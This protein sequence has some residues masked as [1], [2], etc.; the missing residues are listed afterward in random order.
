[1]N[2]DL[3]SVGCYDFGLRK[4]LVGPELR[5]QSFDPYMKYFG[6]DMK[7]LSGIIEKA[8][9]A[10]F[11]TY[12]LSL[13]LL[14]SSNPEF[15]GRQA[16]RLMSS[17]RRARRIYENLR[18]SRSFKAKA[19]SPETAGK[20]RKSEEWAVS[21]SSFKLMGKFGYVGQLKTISRCLEDIEENNLDCD[22]AA[23]RIVEAFSENISSKNI[24]DS[25]LFVDES[26]RGMLS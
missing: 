21:D 9:Q 23:R 5:D 14:K 19:T 20:I 16:E 22:G 10:I 7:R 4:W 11:E 17:L 13:V 2:H 8:R 25:E 24:N 6:K 15:K 18:K 26:I 3:T 12:E 1:M